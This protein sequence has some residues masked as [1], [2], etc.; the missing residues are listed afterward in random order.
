MAAAEHVQANDL[1]SQFEEHRAGLIA[2]CYRMLG[3]FHDAEDATQEALTSGLAQAGW[4]PR[5][6]LAQDLA[7]SH[8]HPRLSG[9]GA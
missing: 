7:L 1:A 6:C 5:R 9:P 2:H 8:R 3:S 4:I